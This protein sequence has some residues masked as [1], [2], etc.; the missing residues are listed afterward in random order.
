MQRPSNNRVRPH[1]DCSGTAETRAYPSRSWLTLDIFATT[2]LGAATQPRAST[3]S[4]SSDGLSRNGVSTCRA[5]SRPLRSNRGFEVFLSLVVLAQRSAMSCRSC[6]TTRAGQFFD[7]N[8]IRLVRQS[9]NPFSRES[10]E[11]PGAI[12]LSCWLQS[13]AP[14]EYN[15]MPPPSQV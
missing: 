1:T 5:I 2:A 4:T 13:N 14:T 3:R 9:A 10:I 12:C 15:V 7:R 6:S 11:Q 8:P